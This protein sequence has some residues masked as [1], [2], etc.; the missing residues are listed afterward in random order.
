MS[1]LELR[2][3]VAVRLLYVYLHSRLHSGDRGSR[4]P[5]FSRSW[6]LTQHWFHTSIVSFQPSFPSRVWETAHGCSGTIP[7]APLAYTLWQRNWHGFQQCLSR[8]GQVPAWPQLLEVYDV[9]VVFIHQSS[10][11]LATRS[12]DT[13]HTITI[14][15][16]E[17]P[18]RH[19]SLHSATSAPHLLHGC[20]RTQVSKKV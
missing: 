17:I 13:I 18:L 8:S 19:L 10:Q 5:S 4:H 16:D 9:T 3:C 2:T 1:T 14:F 20:L 15:A 12:G 11:Q 7:V 6:Y